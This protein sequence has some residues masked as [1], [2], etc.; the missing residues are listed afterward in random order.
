MVDT[1]ENIQRAAVHFRQATERD[2]NFALA[3]AALAECYSMLVKSGHV[4]REK[5][6]QAVEQALKLDDTLPDAYVARGQIRECHYY[7][8]AGAE[9]DFQRAIELNP[10]CWNGHREYGWLLARMGRYEEALVERKRVHELDPVAP[11]SNGNLAQSYQLMG[12][13]DQ[14]R[15]L[16]QKMAELYPEQWEWQRKSAVTY[17]DKGLFDEALEELK[18]VKPSFRSHLYYLGD[19]G[20]IHALMG[21]RAEA[22]KYIESLESLEIRAYQKNWPIAKICVGLRD[23][24]E[25][26]ARL[27]NAGYGGPAWPNLKAYYWTAPLRDDPRF[28]ELLR[29]IN[30]EP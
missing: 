18:K 9:A 4:P 13:F 6:E 22:Q 16:Y 12:D 30:L 26:L 19:A 5:A 15:E 24:E 29:R 20:Y 25:A 3:Y 10:N 21:N 7:D 17:A 27:E 2:P 14:A 11:F 1:L 8:W 28:K 23:Y